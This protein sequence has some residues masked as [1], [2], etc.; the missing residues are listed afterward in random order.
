MDDAEIRAEIERRRKRAVEL[1]LRETM[2]DLYSSQFK[3]IDDYLKKEPDT[4]LPE[5]KDSLTRFGGSSSFRFAGI[6]YTITCLEGGR[7]KDGRG[8]DST[9][10]THMTI[11]LVVAGK[12]TFEFNMRQSVTYGRDMPYFNESM[13]TVTAFIEGTWVEQIRKL[14]DDMRGFKKDAWKKR[15]APREAQRLKDDIERFGL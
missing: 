15:N 13:G 3:Y 8:Y 6:D 9:E 4:I 5:I 1:K 2:W 7:E 14:L 11:S 12:R 10:T